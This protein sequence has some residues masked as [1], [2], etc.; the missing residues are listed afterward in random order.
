M[1]RKGKLL[2]SVDVSSTVGLEVGPLDHPIVAKSEGS[3]FYVDHASRQ[4]LVAKYAN[5]PNVADLAKIVG[6]DFIWGA[7]SLRQTIPPHLSFDYV[8][9]SHVIE[10]VPDVIGWLREVSDVLKPEGMLCLAIPDRRY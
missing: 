6:V 2:H 5:D 10:H 1:D 8:I 7:S 4:D 9:A 3:V